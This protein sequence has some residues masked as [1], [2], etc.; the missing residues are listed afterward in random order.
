MKQPTRSTRRLIRKKPEGAHKAITKEGQR[1]GQTPLSIQWLEH[2]DYLRA[3]R[4]G[5]ITPERW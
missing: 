1:S 5:Q 4:P 3:I 2:R